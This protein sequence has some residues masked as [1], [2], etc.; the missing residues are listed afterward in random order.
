[1]PQHIEH[2]DKIAR[3]KQRDVLFIGFIL[4]TN[5]SSPIYGKAADDNLHL[6]WLQENHISYQ[7]CGL[8]AN[9][10]AMPQYQGHLYIDIPMDEANSD[11]QKLL[12]HFEN[13][14]GSPK[15]AHCVLYYITLAD[16]MKNAHHDEPG[17]WE[18]W[19][20]NF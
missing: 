10:N 7:P 14:D 16:A 2:I 17:F 9:E 11:Y 15:D 13:E 20:E 4:L 18:N 19:A 6:K 12:A 8:I 5:T 3:E 1:M